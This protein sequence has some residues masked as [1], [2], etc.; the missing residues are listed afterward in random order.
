[1][2]QIRSS[3]GQRIKRQLDKWKH[4]FLFKR[5][6]SELKVDLPQRLANRWLNKRDATELA[7]RKQFTI[8]WSKS[9]AI[10]WIARWC[11]APRSLENKIKSV[12]KLRALRSEWREC[13]KWN[14]NDSVIYDQ[15]NLFICL[16][17][18]ATAAAAI[19]SAMQRTKRN[20]HWPN[21]RQRRAPRH[22]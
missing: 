15:T 4:L 3:A 13:E 22:K 19:P 16:C 9:F 1:M 21:A 5:G 18:V 8:Y 17:A 10:N 12:K 20:C 14:I 11:R 2:S 7:H 6:R